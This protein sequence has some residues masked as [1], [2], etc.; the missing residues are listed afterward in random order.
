MISA[1]FFAL[2]F[3]VLFIALTIV[4]S[5]KIQRDS[6]SPEL[7]PIPGFDSI[8]LQLAEAIEQGRQIHISLGI[9]SLFNQSATDTLA[10]LLV[11]DYVSD[12]TNA[13][14]LRAV[15]TTSDP[16]VSIMAQ[17]RLYQ[18]SLSHARVGVSSTL[19]F[20]EAQWISTNPTAYAAGV[21]GLLG[22]ETFESN[23]MIGRFDDTYLMMAEFAQQ[24]HAT[25]TTLSG[26]SD[27]NIL[28]YVFATSPQGIWGEDIFAAGAY[29]MNKPSHIA[30]LLAQDTFRWVIGS[31][32]LLGVILRTLGLVA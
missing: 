3:I 10:G 7:R 30:S 4:Y 32:I 25:S 21:M 2:I 19:S 28:P 23:F 31:I 27:P 29:L 18:P 8:K 9:G 13:A 12:Q 6:L 26:S 15:V 16:T 1:Q 17:E 24:Q 14:G 20:H 5:Y 22:S 11:V